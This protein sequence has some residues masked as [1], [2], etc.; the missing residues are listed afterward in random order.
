[1]LT[2]LWSQGMVDTIA[3]KVAEEP[4]ENI[5][6]RPQH[7]IDEERGDMIRMLRKAQAQR[8]MYDDPC[9]N[10]SGHR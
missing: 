10:W 7:V 6:T 9:M 5:D 8:E 1:M 4:M 3:K 2:Y